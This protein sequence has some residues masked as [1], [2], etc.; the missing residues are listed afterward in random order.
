MSTAYNTG[1]TAVTVEAV[2]VF[3]DLPP[4]WKFAGG[5]AALALDTQRLLAHCGAARRPDYVTCRRDSSGA[6]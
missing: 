5:L 2:T 6:D 4:G 1:L 3:A